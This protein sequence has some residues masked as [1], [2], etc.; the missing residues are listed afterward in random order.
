LASGGVKVSAGASCRRISNGRQILD[1]ILPQQH[2]L[3]QLEGVM[4]G[5]RQWTNV[6][7]RTFVAK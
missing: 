5:G 1:P 3:E 7:Q 4:R 2:G 6:A